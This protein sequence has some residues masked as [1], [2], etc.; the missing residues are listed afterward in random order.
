MSIKL[1]VFFTYWQ[2]VAIAVGEYFG[3]VQ[4]N[5]NYSQNDVAAGIQDYLI[6][7]E[8]LLA[9]I[10]HIYIFPPSD[11]VDPEKP[12]KKSPY[13]MLCSAFNLADS[14]F[15][16]IN[17]ELKKRR[18]RNR[19]DQRLADPMQVSINLAAPVAAQENANAEEDDDEEE[20]DEP[21]Q[22]VRTEPSPQVEMIAKPS[23][24]Q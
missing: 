9:A 5:G 11:F 15:G 12:G 18:E 23:D 8:M 6:C 1:I 16:P 21:K 24:E 13:A 10:A 20:E 22:E 14:M 7:W 3:Y 4:A 17:K 19:R 2:S